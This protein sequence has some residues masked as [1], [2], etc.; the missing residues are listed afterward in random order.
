M[1]SM[2]NLVAPQARPHAGWI[3]ALVSVSLAL[4]TSERSAAATLTELAH[5]FQKQ[6]REQILPYWHDTTLD[7]QRGGYLMA[8]DL[9]GRGLAR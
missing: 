9:K 2:Q 8:D 1:P 5:N 3:F 4:L 7:R 6:L